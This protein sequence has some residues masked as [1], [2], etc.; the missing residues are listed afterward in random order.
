[1]PRSM[2]DPSDSAVAPGGRGQLTG[3]GQVT[4]PGGDLG[5]PQLDLRQV[6]V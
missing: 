6:L 2:G 4:P 3:L 5:Q 1:M